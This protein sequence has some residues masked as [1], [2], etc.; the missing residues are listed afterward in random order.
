MILETELGNQPPICVPLPV[1][2][3]GPTAAELKVQTTLTPPRDLDTQTLASLIMLGLERNDKSPPVEIEEAIFEMAER[4]LRRP[5]QDF[6]EE[7]WQALSE[8]LHQPNWPETATRTTVLHQ[9]GNFVVQYIPHNRS[10]LFPGPTAASEESANR[11]QYIGIPEDATNGVGPY[12]DVATTPVHEDYTVQWDIHRCSKEDGSPHIESYDLL[13]NG[14]SVGKRTPLHAAERL[15]LAAESNYRRRTVPAL[16]NHGG[17]HH[18]NRGQPPTAGADLRAAAPSSRDAH[19]GAAGRREPRIRPLA[20]HRR[21]KPAHAAPASAQ[22]RQA[23][24]RVH[25][26]RYHPE[27]VRDA[28]GILRRVLEMPEKRT[29]RTNGDKDATGKQSGSHKW[30]RPSSATCRSSGTNGRRRPQ[31]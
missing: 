12:P 20:A 24:V 21:A 6:R 27:Q 22:S 8:M 9:H 29:V 10:G 31:P 5:E 19:A 11:N 7:V 2:I 17:K 25:G 18:R 4:T 30:Q 15:R 26:A 3:T 23:T 16:D 28:A 13:I 1:W 14:R